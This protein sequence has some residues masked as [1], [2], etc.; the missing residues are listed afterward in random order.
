M[1]NTVQNIELN[2]DNCKEYT[3]EELLAKI[4]EMETQNFLDSLDW[5]NL[6]NNYMT[7]EE[8]KEC[9]GLDAEEKE[10]FR[11]QNDIKKLIEQ[12]ETR[13]ETQTQ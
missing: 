2:N 13:D 3:T 5:D 4:E 11:T 10:L 12:L 7:D 9:Y 6:E 1:N 8:Y